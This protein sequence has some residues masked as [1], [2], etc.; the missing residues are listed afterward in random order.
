[1]PAASSGAGHQH[2]DVDVGAGVQFAAAVAADRDQRPFVG[3]VG[4]ARLPEFGEHGVEQAGARVH[5]GLD[6]LLGEETGLE[7]G[8]ALAQ[9][10]A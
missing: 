10:G 3:V 4:Q 8:L 5:E 1:M 6:G 7:V 9:H 2:Q